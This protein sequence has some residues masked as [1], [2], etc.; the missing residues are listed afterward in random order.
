MAE[1]V[2]VVIVTYNRRA[3]L[4]ATLAAWAAQTHRPDALVV[5]DNASTD[6]TRAFLAGVPDVQGVPLQ[7]VALAK[8]TGGAGGFAA[9]VRAAVAAGH[10]YVLISDDDACPDRQCLGSLLALQPGGTDMLAAVA[11]DPADG[12]RLCWPLRRRGETARDP[13]I[14]RRSAMR[15]V[16]EIGMA[17][18]LGLLVHRELVARIGYPDAA[19]FLSGDDIEYC[20]RAVAAGARLRQV[21]DAVLTHPLPVFDRVRIAGFTIMCLRL[22]PARQ[23]Y[24]VRNRL[25]NARR[26][27]GAA[28]ILQALVGNIVRLCMALLVRGGDRAALCRAGA[29]GL[30]DGLFARAGARYPGEQQHGR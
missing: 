22:A 26:Y 27:H 13:L 12:D 3:V 10:D 11:V 25:W 24:D 20:L 18:F 19:Y 9:G 16:E 4:V 30:R 1:S 14:E 2:A 29:R 15:P 23:Y 28:G 21:R 17:S 8:N 6:D 7:V 5:V